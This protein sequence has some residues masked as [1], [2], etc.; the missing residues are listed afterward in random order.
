MAYCNSQMTCAS[1]QTTKNFV[2]QMP[3]ELFYLS[4]VRWDQ[5]KGTRC[6]PAVVGVGQCHFLENLLASNTMS[7]SLIC[8]YSFLPFSF[9][10]FLFML[11][12]QYQVQITSPVRCFVQFSSMSIYF[13]T[14]P[15]NLIALLRTSLNKETVT[16]QNDVHL[17]LGAVST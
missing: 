3:R 8:K 14:S 6:C 10:N 13:L 15:L 12:L 11:Y 17:P 4:W 7:A 1:F 2:V 9:F 5:K 16:L